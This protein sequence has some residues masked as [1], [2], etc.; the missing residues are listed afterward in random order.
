MSSNNVSTN[1]REILLCS[2]NWSI[3]HFESMIV[4][5]KMNFTASYIGPEGKE[6]IRRYER[7]EPMIFYSWEPNIF[8]AQHPSTKLYISDSI[9]NC[10]PTQ[11]TNPYIKAN[12]CEQSNALLKKLLSSSAAIIEKD[13]LK[14]YSLYGMSN[15]IVNEM[16]AR[17]TEVL[18][19]IGKLCCNILNYY[20]CEF[21]LQ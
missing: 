14:F 21:T 17:L 18:R 19:D 7:H 9:T 8:L 12:K 3:G 11:N 16:L 1:C 6:I 13:L 5:S 4:E 10:E 2:P 20:A 15:D